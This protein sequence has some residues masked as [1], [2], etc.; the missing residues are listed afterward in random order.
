MDM[1]L[2]VELALCLWVHAALHLAIETV[3]HVLY[4]I[5]SPFEVSIVLLSRT[6]V[7]QPM[8]C[9]ASDFKIADWG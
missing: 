1:Q 7:K 4:R 2:A 3:L 6:V 5:F 9:P 8:P